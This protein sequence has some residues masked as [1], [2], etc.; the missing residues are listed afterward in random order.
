MIQVRKHL[1]A[2]ACAWLLLAGGASA[3]DDASFSKK[4]PSGGEVYLQRESFTEI[5]SRPQRSEAAS[6]SD[7]SATRELDVDH[8]SLFLK[9]PGVA[10]DVL[11][12]NKELIHLKNEP[13]LSAH[14]G[15]F[16]VADVWLGEARAFVLIHVGDF[17]SVAN[18]RRDVDGVWFETTDTNL[19]QD[20]EFQPIVKAEFQLV[21]FS[22]ESRGLA[23]FYFYPARLHR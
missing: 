2:F 3:Q 16:R 10:K 8:Y 22:Q 6:P 9:K 13:W 20:L 12:W 4:F 11:I 18:V 23:Y 17:Y 19:A 5:R 1:I 14:H 21:M 7:A 15:S